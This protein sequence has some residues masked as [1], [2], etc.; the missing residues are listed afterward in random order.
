MD[1]AADAALDSRCAEH[2][3]GWN[4]AEWKE[5]LSAAMP[6]GDLAVLRRAAATGESLGSREF[7]LSLERVFVTAASWTLIAFPYSGKLLRVY[8]E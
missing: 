6:P 5:I 2:F 3:G 8:G 4:L 1:N 7:V